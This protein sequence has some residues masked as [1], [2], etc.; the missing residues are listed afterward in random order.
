MANNPDNSTHGTTGPNPIRMLWINE[1]SSFIGGCEQY[2][3]DSAELLF[4]L[5][6]RSSLLYN[7]NGWTDPKFTGLFDEAYPMAALNRQIDELKPDIIYI[8]R[9]K[10]TGPLISILESGIP[11][12]RFY[13][14]H[15]LF[16]LREHKYT[17]FRNRTCSRPIGLSCYPC[18]GFINRSSD[19]PGIRWSSLGSLRDEQKWNRKLHGFVVGSHYMGS[20]LES[21]GFDRA[22]ILVNPL[23]IR[24]WPEEK[25]LLRV[26]GKMVFAGQLIRGKGVDVAIRAMAKLP[27]FARLHIFGS[28]SQELKFRKLA[29]D[30]G[31]ASRIVFEGKVSH[32]VLFDQYRTASLVLLPSRSPETF[33]LA[34]IDAMSCGAPVVASDVGG[35]REWLLDGMNGFAVPPGDPGKLA[36]KAR[37]LLENNQLQ[38]EMSLRA[39]ESVQTRF[40]ADRHM[41]S[42]LQFIKRLIGREAI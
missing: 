35:I 38:Q 1:A 21:H 23:F 30:C 27:Q 10:G 26:P 25:A 36:E 18:G 24:K 29:Q 28:G 9:L 4:P 13:H 32:D 12:L 33:A 2:I 34:G 41:T 37:Q 17:A 6:V 19:W 8:H 39:R 14:D 3:A 40:M 22:K 11:A 15:G 5:G 16:C 42:L 20:H 7:P 31:L